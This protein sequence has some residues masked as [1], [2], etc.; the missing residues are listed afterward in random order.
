MNR[1]STGF[2]PA[3]APPLPKG[4]IPSPPTVGFNGCH[5]GWQ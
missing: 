4:R 2:P 5:P 1:P 3:F